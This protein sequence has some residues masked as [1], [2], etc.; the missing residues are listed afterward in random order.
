MNQNIFILI[1]FLCSRLF[2][3]CDYYSIDD[4]ILSQDAY[5][6]ESGLRFL[7]FV[8]I[9][10]RELQISE[11]DSLMGYLKK[12]I[13]REHKL[14]EDTLRLFATVAFEGNIADPGE[15]NKFIES[16]R[17]TREDIINLK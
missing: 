1:N 4:S 2:A 9:D 6:F 16:Q 14:R 17:L 11:I 5:K 3:F 13:H 15:G 10:R 12:M 8:L 7:L